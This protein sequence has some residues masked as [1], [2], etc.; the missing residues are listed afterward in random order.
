LDPTLQFTVAVKKKFIFIFSSLCTYLCFLGLIFTLKK[1]VCIDSIVVKKLDI[2]WAT[3]TNR[4]IDTA[5]NCL[6]NV[7]VPYSEKLIDT[8]GLVSRRLENLSAVLSS[9][10]GFKNKIHLIVRYDQPLMFEIDYS[11]LQIG[12][13]LLVADGH[14]QRG[15]IKIWLRE[16]MTDVSFAQETLFEEVMTDFIY[17][18]V[19]GDLSIEDPSTAIQTKL[20]SAQWPRVL[21][22]A[23]A[24]CD[25]AWK[26][27]EHFFICT[28]M[29]SQ[30]TESM[31][32]QMIMLSL[33]PLLTS[34]LI[35][36]YK[37]LNFT[38]QQSLIKNL[39]YFLQRQKISSTRR[40]SLL[41]EHTN[42][43]RQGIQSVKNFSDIFLASDLISTQAY[44]QLYITFKNELQNAGFSDS[45]GEAYFDY[46][47]EMPGQISE[48]SPFFK[49]LQ[50]AAQR[51]LNLQIAIKDQ[52]KIWILPSR[53]AL[54]LA[55]FDKIEARQSLYFS[56]ENFEEL[57]M[58][59][60]FNQTEKLMMIKGCDQSVNYQF[61][62]LFDFGIKQ[63][64]HDNNKL[65]FVQF[66]I[67]S[68]EMK[69]N[70]LSHVNNFFDLVEN[71]D[72]NRQEFRTLGWVQIQWSDDY[73]AYKPRAAVEAIEFFRN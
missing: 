20:G 67:P 15:L 22:N 42:P 23:D 31:S 7:I 19:N 48:Q 70:E 47:I 27:S 54:P 60:F 35:S 33:R 38:Q 57:K 59:R 11:K 69:Q 21:K 49:N 36:A 44:N 73:Y 37:N 34:S 45:F 55:A 50:S 53:V 2:V 63:F 52:Y 40:I 46:L 13:Q 41:L 8:E 9:V 24:Y 12:Y 10:Q 6:L 62:K 66:H 61:D 1:P 51:K 32:Q 56:C 26:S 14:L 72:M 16:N 43:L 17:Y 29:R 64:I 25:S 3:G 65:K 28:Q 68:L 71:R 30:I 39:G 58:E 4:T 5:F 18:I